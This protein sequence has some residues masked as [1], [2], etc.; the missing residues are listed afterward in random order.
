MNKHRNVNNFDKFINECW[1]I[2]PSSDPEPGQQFTPSI[3][4]PPPS[5]PHTVLAIQTTLKLA[6]WQTV[7][8]AQHEAFGKIYDEVT[9]L[10]DQ[11]VETYIGKYGNRDI[12]PGAIGLQNTTMDEMPLLPDVC[13]AILNNATTY[14]LTPE[15][16]ELNNIVDEIRAQLQKLKYLFTLK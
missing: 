11:F 14:L 8:F 7:S 9:I 4:I 5:I 3:C 12:I 16:T 13:L 15:D 2:S 1:S 6:H 10:G